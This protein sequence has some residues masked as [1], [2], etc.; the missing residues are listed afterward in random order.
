MN[1][2]EDS[3]RWVEKLGKSCMLTL[4]GADRLGEEVEEHI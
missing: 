2:F 1:D 4:V 3:Q